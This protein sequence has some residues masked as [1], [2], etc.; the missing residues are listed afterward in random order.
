MISLD[1]FHLP[2]MKMDM[3]PSQWS[4]I[5]AIMLL[6]NSP[7]KSFSGLQQDSNPWPLRSRCSALPKQKPRVQIPLKPQKTFFEPFRNC[8]NCDSLWWSHI[9][10]HLYY[11]SS[12]N[13]ILSARKLHH[14]S[15]WPDHRPAGPG[16][17]ECMSYLTVK[18]IP[19]GDPRAKSA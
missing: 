19:M 4:A 12:D 8:L 9:H 6:Q 2:E 10:F 16:A 17:T 1:R 18:N 3:W 15:E 14:D 7:K 13:F 5:W 11:R